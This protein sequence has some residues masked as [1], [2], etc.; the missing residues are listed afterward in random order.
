VAFRDDADYFAAVQH[1]ERANVLV[2]HHLN[3]VVDFVAGTDRPY[4]TA[5]IFQDDE[6]SS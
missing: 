3:C 6:Q 5:L 1:D 2:G 4:L